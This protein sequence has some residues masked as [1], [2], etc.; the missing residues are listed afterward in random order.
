M[1]KRI[2]D[3]RLLSALI[4][5]GGVGGA[6]MVLG[7]SRTAIYAR[8]K[9]PTFRTQFDEMQGTLLSETAMHMSNSLG[10]AVKALNDVINDPTAAASVRVSAADALLRHCCRYVETASVL[11]RLD[12][13][14]QAQNIS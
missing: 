12:A 3:E 1:P 13:L 9:D 7:V 5:N 10:G 8:L 4:N 2:S 6:A 11:R 14:E